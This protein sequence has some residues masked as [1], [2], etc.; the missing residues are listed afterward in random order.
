MNTNPTR[1]NPLLW[2]EVSLFMYYYTKVGIR[3][4]IH[5]VSLFFVVKVD[6]DKWA[7]PLKSY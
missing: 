2:L 7:C 4:C 1:F 3:I 6:L 5:S